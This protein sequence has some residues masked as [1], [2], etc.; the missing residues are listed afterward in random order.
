MV[1]L[2]S[3]DRNIRTLKELQRVAWQQLADRSATTLECQ[4]LRN[5]LRHTGNELRYYLE[6]KSQRARFRHQPVDDNGIGFRHPWKK[7][8]AGAPND[9]CVPKT[10][11]PTI[12]V[13]KSAK[14]GA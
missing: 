6:M 4:D 12:V 8:A 9:V 10:L 7:A 13:M 11:N 1:E 5:Q 14:D 2:D 3:L